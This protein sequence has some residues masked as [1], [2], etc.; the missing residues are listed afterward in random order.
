MFPEIP[1][2]DGMEV[3]SSLVPTWPGNKAKRKAVAG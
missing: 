3:E 2:K 1:E